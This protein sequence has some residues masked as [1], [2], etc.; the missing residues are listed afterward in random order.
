VDALIRRHQA[1]LEVSESIALHH[2]L[3]ELFHD[4][5]RSLRMVLQFDYLSVRLHDPE[6]QVMRIHVLER[7]SPVELDPELPVG[8]SLGGWVWQHQQSILIENIKHDA[9]FPRAMQVLRDNGVRSCCSLPLSTAHRRLGAMTLGSVRERA[10]QPTDLGFLD[11]VARQV[12]VAVDNALT[13]QHAQSYQQQLA[14]NGTDY[15]C[16]WT[17]RTPWSPVLI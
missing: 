8:E 14:R 16:C 9:R 11:H 1:L 7:S 13:H 15:G 2:D 5:T 6:H 4:L 3:S 12:A 17:S 10:Y